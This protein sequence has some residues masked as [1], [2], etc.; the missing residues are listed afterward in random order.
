[1]GD[2]SILGAFFEACLTQPPHRDARFIEWVV[3]VHP[4]GVYL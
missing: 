2:F 3:C 4:M 1:M